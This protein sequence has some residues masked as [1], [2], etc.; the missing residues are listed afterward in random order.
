MKYS[1]EQHCPKVDTS[2]STICDT[3]R[4]EWNGF[5]DESRFL[6]G[7]Y[8]RLELGDNTSTIFDRMAYSNY[9]ESGWLNAK[10]VPA[11][12]HFATDSS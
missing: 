5:E 1:S 2:L 3:S 4:S 11:P 8:A 7:I 12:I 10:Q 6:N 9:G